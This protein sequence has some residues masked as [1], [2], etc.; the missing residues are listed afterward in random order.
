MFFHLVLP[1]FLLS[2]GA[3]ALWVA[4]YRPYEIHSDYDLTRQRNLRITAW[5]LIT[6][7]VLISA[8][9]VVIGGL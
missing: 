3:Y 8:F 5:S 4:Y 9:F 6:I 2:T 1:G 7:S